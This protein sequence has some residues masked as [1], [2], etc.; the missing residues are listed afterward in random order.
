MLKAGIKVSLGTDGAASNNDLNIFSEMSTAAKLHKAVSGDPMTVDARTV[1][2]MATSWGAGNLYIK[3]L[4]K[5]S[6]GCLADIV[7]VDI[8]K[9]HLTPVYNICSHI[10]YAMRASDV[11]T[12]MVD[13]KVVVSD[14]ELLTGDEKE[15]ILKASEWGKRIKGHSGI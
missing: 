13:G 2:S 10:V 4:G 8:D 11:H 1:M 12:V 14:G 6:E 5:L 7:V 15:I 3:D 9:P